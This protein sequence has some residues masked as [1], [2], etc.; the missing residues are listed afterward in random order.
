MTIAVDWGLKNQ[1]ITTTTTT[2]YMSRDMR[3]PKVWN[4]Q[5]RYHKIAHKAN[6]LS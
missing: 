4:H 5:K 2:Q 1:K 3:V 6:T